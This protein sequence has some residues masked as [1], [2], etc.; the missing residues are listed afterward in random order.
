MEEV[1]SRL[2]REQCLVYLDDVLVVEHTVKKSEE[3][4]CCICWT[5]AET[6]EML[7]DEKKVFFLG[8]IVSAGGVREG[9]S[10]QKLACANRSPST[11]WFPRIDFILSKV[12]PQLLICRSTSLLVDTEICSI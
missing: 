3:S 9:E 1:L 6:S 7:F 5:E 8:Y 10:C 12:R 11:S 2:P 4:V